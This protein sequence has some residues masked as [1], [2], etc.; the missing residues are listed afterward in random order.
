[1]LAFFLIFRDIS[2]QKIKQN[3]IDS[4]G[5]GGRR[6]D[7]VCAVAFRIG[8]EICNLMQ[9]F[10]THPLRSKFFFAR[11]IMP[12]DFRIFFFVIFVLY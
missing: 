12:I 4:G 10:S 7:V 5:A 3:D 9:P 1:M 2:G 11:S 6:I 8:A